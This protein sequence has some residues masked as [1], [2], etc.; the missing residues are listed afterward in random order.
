MALRPEPLLNYLGDRINQSEQNNKR[1][2]IDCTYSKLGVM[3]KFERLSGLY[4]Y[5]LSR[6]TG[7]FFYVFYVF[8]QN[9]KKHDFLRFLWLP[10]TFSRTLGYCSI[11]AGSSRPVFTV[12][13]TNNR[14]HGP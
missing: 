7:T 14:A 1:F 3:V 8:F 4:N 12:H 2:Q 10:H 6:P 9:P 5:R 11:K 13:K